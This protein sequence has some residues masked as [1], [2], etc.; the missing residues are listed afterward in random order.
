MGYP[1]AQLTSQAKE[2]APKLTRSQH[3][4]LDDIAEWQV[5][6]NIDPDLDDVVYTDYNPL[7]SRGIGPVT[8]FRALFWLLDA[9]LIAFTAGRMPR[10]VLTDLGQRVLD[11]RS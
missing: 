3:Q 10:V 4:V 11:A 1:S 6:L 5:Q 2:L 8:R 9:R 7:H